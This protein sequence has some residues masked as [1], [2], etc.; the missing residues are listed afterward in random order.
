MQG[1]AQLVAQN[2]RYFPVADVRRKQN[3]RNAVVAQ[4]FRPFVIF[5]LDSVGVIDGQH[6]QMRIF[7]ERA[8]QIVPH[9]DDDFVDFGGCFFGKSLHQ[10]IARDP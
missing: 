9:A 6:A 7:D 3:A 2:G 8:H 5:E 1:H 4:S 10:V